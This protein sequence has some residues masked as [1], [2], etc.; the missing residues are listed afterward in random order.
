MRE[1]GEVGNGE[2]EEEEEGV[3]VRGDGVVDLEEEG[4]HAGIRSASCRGAVQLSHGA[5]GDEDAVEERFD[6]EAY[7]R[8]SLN[9]H[10]LGGSEL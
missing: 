2:G 5:I 3:D 1:N 4:S 10:A 9:D 8:Q 6:A 7:E